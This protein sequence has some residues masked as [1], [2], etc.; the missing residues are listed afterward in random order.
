MPFKFQVK[1]AFKSNYLTI[2]PIFSSQVSLEVNE[3]V[4]VRSCLPLHILGVDLA[5]GDVHASATL[6]MVREE[7]SVLT[8][9]PRQEKPG[10]PKDQKA[11]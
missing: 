3:Y 9:I 11:A 6:P 1:A 7:T 5:V 4:Q 8:H 2:I 10:N